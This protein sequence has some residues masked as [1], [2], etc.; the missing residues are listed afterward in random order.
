MTRTPAETID[1]YFTAWRAADTDTLRAIFADDVHFSGPLAQLDD[2]DTIADSLGQLAKATK[3]IVIRRRWVDGG[4]VITWFDL[5]VGD[6]PATPVANWSHVENG[7]VTE[8]RVTFD[9]RGMLA[10]G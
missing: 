4:D 9:P 5:T 7:L 3:D 8:I 1:L 6:A 2:A 10:S